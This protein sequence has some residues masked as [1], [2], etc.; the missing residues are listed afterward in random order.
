MYRI[1]LEH[2]EAYGNLGDEAMLMNA[3]R[4][5]RRA[6]GEVE[7]VVPK[8]GDEPLPDIGAVKVIPSPRPAINRLMHRLVPFGRVRKW[9]HQQEYDPLAMVTPLMMR[10]LG[11]IGE[12]N[13]LLE[14]LRSCDGVYFVGAANLNDF[15][16]FNC[17]LPKYALWAQAQSL[18]KPVIMSSQTV[19]PLE[20]AWPQQ[21]VRR[22]ATQSKFFSVRDGGVSKNKLVSIGVDPE[23][24]HFVGDEA[25]SLPPAPESDVD[26]YLR[27]AGV[28]S[29]R[30]FALLHFRGTDY[31]QSTSDYYRIIAEA[32][33]Q[34]ET[35][36][37]V[38]FLP[39]SY[40]THSTQDEE[41]GRSIKAFMR[42]PD[43]LIVLPT[44]R[45]V[46]VAKGLF[47][48]AW[49]AA[50]LS[51]HV[52]VFALSATCPILI[53]SSGDYY[54]VKA[55]GMHQLLEKRVPLLHI[56]GLDPSEL[57]EAM[58]ELESDRDRQVGHLRAIGERVRAVN[59]G[60][61]NAMR[62]AVLQ[63]NSV[64]A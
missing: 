50:G 10:L 58:A 20:M 34:V 6:L 62:E 1:Y 8:I 16:R 48:K 27:R 31:T 23:H 60:P 57:A 49:W 64:P 40:W 28:A 36:A 41:C 35:D 61:V 43:K 30:P 13:T 24:I 5:L 59:D 55:E 25:F 52:Q 26:S 46:T 12:W 9:M 17:V 14:Q 38:C 47:Q 42:H 3:A 32:L 44:L 15:A 39:M 56:D 53:L 37:Q 21:M 63:E 29:D 11:G 33:D 18:G 4:R 19:G 22:M 51:Y 54:R 45:D 2:G 7:F